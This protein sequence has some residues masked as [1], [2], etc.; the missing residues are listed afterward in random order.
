MTSMYPW[1]DCLRR[2][3]DAAVARHPSAAVVAKRRCASAP[4]GGG[5]GVG[6]GCGGLREPGV[7][8]GDG[9]QGLDRPAPGGSG[10]P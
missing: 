7:V 10:G 1:M 3:H 6:A 9:D 8:V 5:K 4:A 2:C